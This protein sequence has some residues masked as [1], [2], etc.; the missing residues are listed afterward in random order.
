MAAWPVT[1]DPGSQPYNPPTGCGSK[2]D[3]DEL[4]T[5]IQADLSSFTTGADIP[6]DGGVNQI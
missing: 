6:V 1:G 4:W 3:K 5:D 2:D